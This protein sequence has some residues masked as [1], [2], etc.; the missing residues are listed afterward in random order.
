MPGKVLITSGLFVRAVESGDGSMQPAV[1]I[2]E[3]AGVEMAW[4]FKP[5]NDYTVEDFRAV[6]P[7]TQAVIAGGEKW[8]EEMF[9]VSPD[10]R[11]IARF[12]VGFD[13]VDLVKA[14]EYGI[15]VANTRVHELSNSVAELALTLALDVY[16]KTQPGCADMKRG[17]W[18]ARSGNQV[19]GKTVGIVGFGAIGR[20]FAELLSGFG[21]RVIACDPYPDREAAK[22]LKVELASMD[23]VLARSDIVSLS[24]PN[25][26]ENR[27][28][29]NA[30]VF[31]KMKTG[32]VFVNTARGAMVNEKDLYA[33]LTSGKLA[34]AGLDVW[35]KE[36]TPADNPLLALEN[37]VCLPHV[38]GETAESSLAMAVCNAQQVVDMLSGKTPQFLLNP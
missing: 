17:V 8:N 23:E 36:P 21:A 32:A 5:D 26:P 27:H 34:G 9:K 28:M 2:L 38:A 33:A 19:R 20:C 11:L 1:D 31:A 30:A 12:G 22:R 10:L 14:R 15:M 35:E 7:G 24:A 16:R 37:V 4:M 13:A 6:M 18:K 29:F 3:K 25:T